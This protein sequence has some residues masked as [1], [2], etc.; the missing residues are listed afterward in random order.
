MV[1][2]QKGQGQST[3]EACMA[4][5]Y[6]FTSGKLATSKKSDGEARIFRWN[7]L[8]QTPSRFDAQGY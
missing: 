6:F 1:K 2:K 7:L 4:K 8:G 5:S 3:V